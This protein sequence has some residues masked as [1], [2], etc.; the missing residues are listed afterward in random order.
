MSTQCSLAPNFFN[1]PS[2]KEIKKQLI[3]RSIQSYKSA[4]PC[5]CPY[6][7]NCRGNNAWSRKG[8]YEPYCYESDIQ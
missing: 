8:G 7:G 4:G 1:I 2:D 3:E 6:S 5:P